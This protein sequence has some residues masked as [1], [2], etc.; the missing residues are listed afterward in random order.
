MPGA[1]HSRR[2]GVRR[3]SSSGV[4]LR[5]TNTPRE[6]VDRKVERLASA[7]QDA[8]LRGVLLTTHWNFSWLTAGATNRIDISREAGAGA[9]LV[10]AGGR[11]YALANAIEMPRLADEVLAGL[12]FEPIEFAWVDERA[13]PAFLV[14]RATA[15]LSG[16]IG[17]DAVLGDAHHFETSLSRLRS[18]L[19]P[20]ELRR[21]QGAWG[22][23]R[24]SSGLGAPF[25]ACRHQ[26]ARGGPGGRSLAAPREHP[27]ACPPRRC[28]QSAPATSPSRSHRA[29]LGQSLDGR[30]LRGARWARRRALPVAVSWPARGRDRA[31][32][33]GGA[34]RARRPAGRLAPWSLGCESLS[35]CR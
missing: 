12:D 16:P 18:A 14:Q 22:G 27:T 6:E 2:K 21:Y 19:E 3:R 26:R 1:R 4:I 23:R 7:A 20:E 9:L 30:C 17:C 15:L 24:P 5:S 34:R 8:G 35:S 28:R 29:G 25:R 11:R 10:S 13:N 31:K 33:D 32:T